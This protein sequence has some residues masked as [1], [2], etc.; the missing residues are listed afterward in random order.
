MAKD[1]DSCISFQFS[2]LTKDLD[3]HVCAVPRQ[4]S[5][6]PWWT[7]WLFVFRPLITISFCAMIARGQ[8][9]RQ[10]FY[11]SAR[12][13]ETLSQPWETGHPKSLKSK[14]GFQIPI[15]NHHNTCNQDTLR[16][17]VWDGSI[18]AAGHQALTGASWSNILYSEYLRTHTCT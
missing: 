11:R 10:L 5:V 8:V 2:L 9:K 16:V 15:H 18:W 17:Y 7:C 1:I 14:F 4:N 3:L 6:L 12:Q 13:Y